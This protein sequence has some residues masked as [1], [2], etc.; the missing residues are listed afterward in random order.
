[1]GYPQIFAAVLAVSVVLFI[2]SCIRRFRLVALGKPEDRLSHFWARVGN[3]LLFAF[4]QKRVVARPFGVNHFV[5][6]WCFLVLA[7]ASALMG[8]IRKR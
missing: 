5:I 1:M 8:V 6:F 3:M 4:G 7:V 2:V